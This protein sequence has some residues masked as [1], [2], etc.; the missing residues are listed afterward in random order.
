MPRFALRSALSSTALAAACSSS[1][2]TEPA[3]PA[4]EARFELPTSGA[5][6]FLQVPFPSDL[7][8]AE[9]GTI[10]IAATDLERVIPKPV[11]AQYIAESLGKT[12]GFGVYGGALFELTGGA[13]DP[14]KLPTGDK[15]DCQGPDS[16]VYLVDVDAGVALP[17][18]AAWNDDRISNRDQETAPVL[19]VRTARGIVLPEKHR[20]AVLLTSKIT[21]AGGA[22]LAASAGFARV[23]D[24]ARDG[25]AKAYGD[26]I[27]AAIAKVGVGKERVVSAAVYTTGEVTA[28]LRA[29]REIAKAAPVPE[30]QWN[31]ERLAP[32][33]AAKFLAGDK[34][35]EGW[36]ATLDDYLGT[37]RKLPSGGDD[38]DWDAENPGIAHD[39]L[40]AIGVAAF[41][42]PNFL[43][44]EADQFASPA[45]GTFAHGADGRVVRDPDQPSLKIWVS[46]FV[47]K[48]TMPAGGWPTVVFQ[49]GMGGQR[50]DALGVANVFAQKGWAVAAIDAYLQGSRGTDVVARGDKKHD[51]S[52][53]TSKYAGPDGFSDRNAE[54][55]NFPPTDLFGSLFRIAALR[56]QFR[57]TA[58]DHVTLLR[59]LSSSPTLDGLAIDGNAPKIDGSRVAYVGNSL[60]GILGGIVAGIEPDHRAYV[61]NVPGGAL[62]SE[63]ATNSPNI[64]SLLSLSATLNFGF[65]NTQLPSWHP[66]VQLMQHIVDGG[67]PIAVAGTASPRNALL[68]EVLADELV[69]NHATEA[70]AKAMGVPIVGSHAPLL[71]DLVEVADGASAA[72]TTKALVQSYPAAHGTNLY[73]G[74]ARREYVAGVPFFGEAGR[75]PFPKLATPKPIANP[76]LET[77]AF[78]TGFLAEVFEGKAP[79]VKGFAAP[80]I[81]KE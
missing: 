47:P 79:I 51:F 49:H 53:T 74:P 58:L 66:M 28:E 48:G 76:Y 50:G 45:H 9:D 55:A 67:D 40:S 78:V 10:R 65:A 14:A 8:L 81:P 69:P 13:P 2:T 11:G 31:A 30:L 70:L 15:G 43:V 25:A 73:V 77:Q 35:P 36:T 33:A 42:A 39:A 38:P 34:L 27:D 23:R 32:I 63:L 62:M 20:I 71:A 29:A 57:Q 46:F 64:Y 17:C 21:T 12:R 19:T 52:R 26:A 80:E 75:E 16:S 24:G 6:A 4:F 5:P 22:P 7:Q 44:Q 3:G 61:L 41:D 60:G 56:D 72:G 18:Q 68:I 37:P 1:P 59:I 54:G